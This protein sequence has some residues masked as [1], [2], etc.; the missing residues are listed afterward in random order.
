ME[1]MREPQVRDFRRLTVYQKTMVWVGQ[2]REIVKSWKWE[3]RQVIGNQILRAST[4]VAAN[5]SESNA[6]L[7]LQKEISFLNNAL[8]SCGESQMWLEEA[9]NAKLIDQQTF[10]CLDNE[11]VEVR[12]MLVAM[13]RK[14]K[15]EIRENRRAG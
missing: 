5:I 6:Q 14:I 9:R 13:I 1:A 2:I 7:Y 15:L 11:A 8:G 3:D 4:S 12:K 10:E